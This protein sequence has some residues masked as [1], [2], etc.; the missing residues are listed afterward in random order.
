MKHYIIEE[1][2]RLKMFEPNNVKKIQRLQQLLDVEVYTIKEMQETGTMYIRNDFE[3]LYAGESPELNS[4]CTDVIRYAGGHYIQ[5][6][7]SGKYL[8]NYIGGVRGKRSEKLEE[9]EQLIF[10]NYYNE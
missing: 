3:N 4:T 8:V 9:I 1:I 2:Q 6:L 10:N 7:R 5:M